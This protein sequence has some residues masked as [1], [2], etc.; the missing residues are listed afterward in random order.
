MKLI[1]FD[2]NIPHFIKDDGT[3]F[4]GAAVDLY[5]Q[6]LGLDSLGLE[7]GLVT[8]I[9]AKDYISQGVREAPFPVFEAYNRST[10]LPIFHTLFHKLP[11]LLLIMR[12]IN[13]SYVTA[14]GAGALNGILLLISKAHKFKFIYQMANDIESDERIYRK[15]P[16]YTKPVFR[17][18]LSRSDFIRCQNQ[19]Q[20]DNIL[21]RYPKKK[22][23]LVRNATV[24]PILS[25]RQPFEKRN[26]VL[27]VGTFRP[28]KKLSKFYKLCRD[29]P[30]VKFKIAGSYSGVTDQPTRKALKDLKKLKNVEMLGFVRHQDVG[31][32]YKQAYCLVCTSDHEG[33]P[34]TFLEAWLAGTPVVTTATSNPDG[35]I[36]QEDLGFVVDND[37]EL[38]DSVKRIFQD[39]AVFTNLSENC[40]K[41]VRKH[42][43][44]KEIARSFISYLL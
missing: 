41:F 40:E 26:H 14:K 2:E 13:P 36:G 10:N 42:H 1:Y 35:L 29:L 38:K 23:F 7:T 19:Y 39:K 37:T 28:Q 43:D 20:K 11:R 12:K 34:N 6:L 31:K 22:V 33:F 44:H 9:G 15:L 21:K 16:F 17:F 3:P 32:L 25:D 24:I 4:G 5:Y 8:W 18:L 30:D 27:W